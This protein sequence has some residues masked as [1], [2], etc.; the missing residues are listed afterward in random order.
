M[1]MLEEKKDKKKKKKKD[2]HTL[3]M[4]YTTEGTK[5]YVLPPFHR[6]DGWNPAM[7]E[8]TDLNSLEVTKAKF[9]SERKRFH[10]LWAKNRKK[11]NEKGDTR[12]A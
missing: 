3:L 12:I 4:I 9:I 2:S 11:L 8:H 5:Y 6:I 1:K 10:K 7:G